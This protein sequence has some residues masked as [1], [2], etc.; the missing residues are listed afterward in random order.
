MQIEV[1]QNRHTRTKRGGSPQARGG[2]EGAAPKT[3]VG[4]TTLPAKCNWLQLQ[5]HALVLHKKIKNKEKKKERKNTYL[6]VYE[7]QKRGG[8]RWMHAPR[9]VDG[10]GH[11]S[12]RLRVE[13]YSMHP[14]RVATGQRHGPGHLAELAVPVPAHF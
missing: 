1:S 7:T 8:G 14:L 4:R 2:E 11:H 6:S 10:S 5:R 13:R 12:R 9:P 3:P